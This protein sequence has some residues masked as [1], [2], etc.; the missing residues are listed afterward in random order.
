MS[1]S[2]PRPPVRRFSAL[3]DEERAVL[4]AEWERVDPEGVAALRRSAER[5]QA[6]SHAAPYLSEGGEAR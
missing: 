6:K 2:Q 4:E 3:T 1:D 5:M